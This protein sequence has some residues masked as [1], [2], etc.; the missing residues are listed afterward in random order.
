MRR[1]PDAARTTRRTAQGTSP[2]RASRFRVDLCAL[3]L[4]GVVDVADLDLRVEIVDRPPALTVPVPRLLHATER[5]VRLGAD[6]GGVHV[7]DAVVELV[8]CAESRVHVAGVEST[9]EP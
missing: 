8:E 5:E 2:R 1:V 9:G 6:G 3:E 7:G 4:P